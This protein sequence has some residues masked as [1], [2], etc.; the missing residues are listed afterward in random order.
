MTLE[1]FRMIESVVPCGIQRLRE[2]NVSEEDIAIVASRDIYEAMQHFSEHNFG[3][4]I[5]DFHATYCGYNIYIIEQDVNEVFAPAV[6]N[7]FFT[8]FNA[9]QLNDGDVIIIE[10]DDGTDHV[11][12]KEEADGPAIFF[13]DAEL[14]V[15]QAHQNMR[16]EY[17]VAS[18]LMDRN[19]RM[20]NRFSPTWE[21]EYSTDWL[22]IDAGSFTSTLEQ[23]LEAVASTI[24]GG[25][26]APVGAKK[27]PREKKLTS[28][29]TRELDEFLG[30]FKVLE[31]AT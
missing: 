16:S 20:Y 12:T 5:L 18:G 29:D 2:A 9:G 24:S 3:V 4:N 19:G 25:A 1:E 7:G 6:Q 30:S 27:P 13:K 22:P 10:S 15:R 17:T 31:S 28:E 21:L 11:Y 8:Q 23:Q 26:R 14:T